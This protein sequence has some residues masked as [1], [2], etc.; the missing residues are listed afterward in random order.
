MMLVAELKR[1]LANEDA[2]A[3]AQKE[4]TPKESPKPKPEPKPAR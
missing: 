4:T 2:L 1:Q 3:G